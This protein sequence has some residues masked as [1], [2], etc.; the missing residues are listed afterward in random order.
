[1][2]DRH[3]CIFSS[4][5]FKSVKKHILFRRK[6]NDEEFYNEFCNIMLSNSYLLPGLSK[7]FSNPFNLFHYPDLVIFADNSITDKELSF[8][9][10]NRVWVINLK[11]FSKDCFKFKVYYSDSTTIEDSQMNL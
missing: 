5:Y 9:L 6:T 4:N 7:N 11:S 3:I 8:K 2:N 10:A 1:M